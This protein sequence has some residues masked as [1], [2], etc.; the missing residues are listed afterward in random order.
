MVTLVVIGGW[1]EAVQASNGNQEEAVVAAGL[2]SAVEERGK[3]KRCM[4]LLSLA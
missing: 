2:E 3:W 1:V 4:S